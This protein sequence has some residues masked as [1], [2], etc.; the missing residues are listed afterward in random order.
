MTAIV[1]GQFPLSNYVRNLNIFYEINGKNCAQF[2]IND[3]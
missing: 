2:D 1:C 3:H